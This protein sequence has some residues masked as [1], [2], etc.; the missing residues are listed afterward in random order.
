MQNLQREIKEIEVDLEQ[1]GL[2]EG[3]RTAIEQGAK[4]VENVAIEGIEKRP[5]V[6]ALE[7]PDL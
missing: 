6:Q 2:S 7:L 4:D 1:S 5:I 3:R